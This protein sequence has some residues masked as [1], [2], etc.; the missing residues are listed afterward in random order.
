MAISLKRLFAAVTLGLAMAPA[1]V[2]AAV[3]AVPSEIMSDVE[4]QVARSDRGYLNLWQLYL[5]AMQADPRILAAEGRAMSGEGR[6]IDARG[7][8]LPQLSASGSYQRSDRRVDPNRDLYN[9]E[10]YGLNL[11]QVIFNASAWRNYQRFKSLAAQRAAE[12]QDI[13]SEAAVDLAQRYFSALA[14]EDELALTQAERRAM[15]R[16]LDQVNS[17]YERRLAK[18]TDVLQ[19]SAR[20]DALVAREI[21]AANNVAVSRAALAEV[22]GY[23]IDQRLERIRPDAEFRMPA[24][25]EHYWIQAALSSNPA[26][27]ARQQA[28]AAAEAGVGEARGGHL[29][30]VSL[31]AS[32]Q[33]SD[34]GYENTLMPETETFVVGVGVQ[35]PIFSGGSTSGRVRAAYGELTAA[36]QDYEALRRE[37]ERE[38]RTAYL[39]VQASVSKVKASERALVSA[40][41][42][43]VAAERG[44]SYG[45]ETAVDVLNAIQE[46]YRARRDYQQAQYEFVI[47]LLVLN[48]WGGSLGDEHIQMANGWLGVPVADA[49]QG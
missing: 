29:P 42:A 18:I 2:F 26:L 49:T 30:T 27:T 46:E 48:R 6:R 22:V 20:V 41:K 13:R 15:Q 16:N 36:Q 9:G 25:D 45:V 23:P 4:Q 37:I 10:R 28:V 11:S 12:Y 5:D 43:R 8:L 1:A 40:E 14:A 38:V 21:E 44:F 3:E 33:Q 24:M 32:A 19:I 17:L 34:I 39:N 7:Q 35:I 31:Y 47:G